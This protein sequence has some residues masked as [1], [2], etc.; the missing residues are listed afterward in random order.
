MEMLSRKV[1]TETINPLEILRKKIADTI[2]AD[3]SN[4]KIE[5]GFQVS[6]NS[7]G[8]LVL[9]F[10]PKRVWVWREEEDAWKTVDEDI[11]R[12]FD[13]LVVLNYSETHQLLGF[14]KELNVKGI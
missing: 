5:L 8:H 6:Y 3:P 4:L 7:Y 12:M 9:R 10:Y 14:V 2:E 13:V 11:C 1:V